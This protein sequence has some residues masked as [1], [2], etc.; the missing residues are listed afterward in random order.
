MLRLVL[1]YRDFYGKSPE[2]LLKSSIETLTPS[3]V[4]PPRKILELL[5]SD[6][7]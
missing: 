4:P 1:Q 3:S 2:E 7:F 5:I 6:S